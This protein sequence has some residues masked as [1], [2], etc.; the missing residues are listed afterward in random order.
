MDA[1][2]QLEELCPYIFKEN[3]ELTEG[4][5]KLLSSLMIKTVNF[6]VK[7][8]IV[9][10]PDVFLK[11]FMVY[12]YLYKRGIKNPT[13]D[14]LFNAY[15]Q[16]SEKVESIHRQLLSSSKETAQKNLKL[17]SLVIKELYRLIDHLNGVIESARRRIEESISEALKKEDLSPKEIEEL[18]ET[19]RHIR[20]SV[21]KEVNRIIERIRSL[22]DKVDQVAKEFES[23][24]VEC[25]K[26]NIFK[27]V[28]RRLIDRCAH[29]GGKF[30]FV[31][32]KVD[33]WERWEDVP[34]EAKITY[35]DRICAVF[36][37]ELRGMDF[38][39]CFPDE[40]L[41]AVVIRGV[42]IKIAMRVVQRLLPVAN[43]VVVPY[44]GGS[45]NSTF[46][47]ALVEGRP[48]DTF[49]KL[50]ERAKEVLSACPVNLQEGCIRSEV[51]LVGKKLL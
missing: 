16:V 27:A 32:A 1:E 19:F 17:V 42:G 13:Y 5:R 20:E 6:M 9:P 24:P 50:M 3:Q 18:H 14:T 45:L 46:S 11:W 41:F 40:G 35:M 44:P 36:K 31:L 47:F 26:L 49:G 4:E 28:V 22:Q 29:V 8:N 23:E 39:T 38:V 21:T 34:K 30:T 37:S 10:K 43:E 25:M 51:D 15:D 12:C 7:A 2:K 33:L 48:I